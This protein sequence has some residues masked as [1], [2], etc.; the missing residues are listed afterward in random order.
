MSKTYSFEKLNV[1]KLARQLVTDIY[2]LT[3]TFPKEER[4]GMTSQLRRAAC[5]VPNNLAEGSARISPKEQA[6]FT[7]ISFG[8]LME[9]LN[10]LIVSCD[11]GFIST[12]QV[13]KQR[14]LIDEIGNKLN[15]L[16]ESQ[17]K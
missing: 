10:E 8:S 5:S 2:Q 16:R 9:V 15:K 3:S 13:E 14:P 11:L 6:R 17:L 1:W 4:F 12:E 7:E